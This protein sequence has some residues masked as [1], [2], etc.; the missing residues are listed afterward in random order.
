VAFSYIDKY[1]HRLVNVR[2]TC[3]SWT[4]M[5]RDR[6]LRVSGVF[7]CARTCAQVPW[8]AQWRLSSWPLGKPSSLSSDRNRP[9]CFPEAPLAGYYEHVGRTMG[10]VPAAFPVTRG[11][12]GF[13]GSVVAGTTGYQ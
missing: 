11:S 4:D 12:S 13:K 9:E 7:V 8:H 1:S 6:P 10:F 3:S 5:A 2:L